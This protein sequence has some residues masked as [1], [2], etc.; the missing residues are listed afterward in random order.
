MQLAG[1]WQQ[2]AARAVLAPTGLV[3]ARYG[4][5]TAAEGNVAAALVLLHGPR[6]WWPLPKPRL[7]HVLWFGY[8]EAVHVTPMPCERVLWRGIN[9]PGSVDDVQASGYCTG[10]L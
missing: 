6:H 10:T 8:G 2:P 1:E 9:S 7:N 4:T 3:T 5:A